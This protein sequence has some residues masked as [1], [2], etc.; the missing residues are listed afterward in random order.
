M[1]ANSFKLG[2]LPRGHDPRIPQMSK[3]MAMRGVL[4]PLPA[5][6]NYSKGMPADLGAMLNDTLGDCVPAACGH[7]IQA[8]SFNAGTAMITPPDAQIETFYEIAGGYVPGNPNTDNG[9]VEQVALAD[10]LTDPI[11][12]N[13]LTAFIEVNPSNLEYVKR[14]IW[15]SGLI[16]C[17]FNVPAYLMNKLTAPGSVWN[18]DPG[19]DNTIVGGHAV[20][21]LGYDEAGNMPLISW[22]SLYTMTPQFWLRFV[23]EAYALANIAWIKKTGLSPAGLTIAE[24][25][26][27]MQTMKGHPAGI[28]RHHR[29]RLRRL[30]REAAV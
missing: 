28:R 20:V 7:A 26:V 4:T 17:G 24:L 12:G 21:L 5:A 22:G 25:Q 29:R 6:V 16:F 10:W 27:L 3:L 23:D 8:W 2:R 1:T 14:T 15:E 13:E 18:V 9:T 11:D 30:A 19:Q